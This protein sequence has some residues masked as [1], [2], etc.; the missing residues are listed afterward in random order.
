[1]GAV[2]FPEHQVFKFTD[3]LIVIHIL[4]FHENV[5][6]NE[7]CELPTLTCSLALRP[8]SPCREEPARPLPR[9]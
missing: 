1:V 9:W 6:R 8:S 5:A 2:G 7:K 4:P 3:G